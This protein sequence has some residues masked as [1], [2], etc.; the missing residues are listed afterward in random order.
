VLHYISGVEQV[1]ATLGRRKFKAPLK[2][3]SKVPRSSENDMKIEIINTGT[4]LMLGYVLNTHQQWLCRE[5]SDLGYRVER[6]TAI[7]D[8]GPAIQEA[9]REAM[10]RADLIITT[11]GL[12]PTSDDLTRQLI[13]ELL[14]TELREDKSVRNRIETFFTRRNRPIPPG[15]EVQALV[16]EGA[17]V[18]MNEFGTAPGLWIPFAR[19][20]ILMLPGPPRELRPMFTNQAL[21]LIE[22]HFGRIGQTACLTLKSTGIGESMVEDRIREAIRPLIERGLAVGYCAR[23]GEVDVRLSAHGENGASIVAEAE[24][25]VRDRLDKHVFGMGDD[26]LEGIVVKILAAR[27]ASLALAESCTG[28][29]I[30]NRI[31][32][33][34][35][36]SAVFKGGAV[37]YSN[38]AKQVLLD[39]S[40]VTLEKF[41]AVS[42]PTAREMAEGA[43]KRFNADYAISV[44]GIAGPN[45]GTA[46]KPVGTVFIGL[47][48]KA[49]TM[50][51]RQLNQF[52]RE[53]FK[54]LTSQ[55]AL[56]IVRRRLLHK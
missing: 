56:E 36:A 32:N 24:G 30:A 34:S 6:Q 5:L 10:Q 29:Y 44:T 12:G 27:N 11:G 46:E 52:D 1:N 37:T 48:E 35:G 7:N 25:I 33:I 14:Q 51:S 41:G 49:Q 47:A 39:V 53:T 20:M 40:V 19:G 16:P 21:S 4:E 50:V 18:L 28:G 42:E 54:F 38:E 22:A 23:V 13:A 26:S 2:P 43:L 15:T 45:G 31:T 17:Q 3:E 9:V 8:T 55:Q